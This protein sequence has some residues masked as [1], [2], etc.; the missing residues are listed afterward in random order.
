MG[1]SSG[2]SRPPAAQPTVAPSTREDEDVRNA[3]ERER[4]RLMRAR[5]RESTFLV[6]P[7]AQGAEKLGQTL[8]R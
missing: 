1:S 7:G 5:G 8:V 4:R 6:S 2:S 3:Y